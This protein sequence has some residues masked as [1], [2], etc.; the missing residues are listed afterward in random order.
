MTRIE[1]PEM[2]LVELL[3]SAD[4]PTDSDRDRIRKNVALQIAAGAAL[5]ATL[6]AAERSAWL[7]RWGALSGWVKGTTLAVALVAAGSGVSLLAMH[8][9]AP[10]PAV[11]VSSSNAVKLLPAAKANEQSTAR[12]SDSPA[13]NV[14]ATAPV[15]ESKL[16]ESRASS[17][18]QAIAPAAAR[19]SSRN[20][21][22]DL[23]AELELLGSAQKSLKAGQ[24]EEALKALDE[25][26]RRFPAGSLAFERVGVRTV[27]LC[28]AGR[29]SEGRTAARSYLRKV[30]NSVLSKRIRVA[31]Q[32]ADE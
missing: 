1:S 26:Q 4:D 22:G 28:Q 14:A 32:L 24:P 23:E 13:Q 7:V 19:A 21:A 16:E 30:P 3:R 15:Q 2:Q 17:R 20:G 8:H 31:C 12:S 25:H 11:D 29:F 27:A 6:V 18:P 9:G 5:S 10:P